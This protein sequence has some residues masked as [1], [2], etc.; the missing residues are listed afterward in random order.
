M[1]SDELIQIAACA[2]DPADMMLHDIADDPRHVA[3]AEVRRHLSTVGDDFKVA[4]ELEREVS[5]RRLRQLRNQLSE[6]RPDPYQHRDLRALEVDRHGL[7]ELRLLE[8]GQGGF[9]SG[10]TVFE[11][12]PSIDARNSSYWT[13]MSLNEFERELRPRIRL[14][15]LMRTRRDR[16]RS[17]MY[18]MLVYGRPLRW[19]CVLELREE[20]HHRWTP[21]RQGGDV[22]FTDA[23]WTPRDNEV[24][25]RC[26]ECPTVSA[27]RYRPSRYLHAII[28]R[29]IG[30]VVHTDGALRIFDHDE[31]LARVDTHVRRAGKMGSRIK[32]FQLDGRLDTERWTELLQA[33]FIWNDDI[34]EFVG[35]LVGGAV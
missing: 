35:S 15:P 13:A 31:A 2:S 34:R 10:E 19:R 1:F 6:A 20:C 28:D 32:L 8:Q 5:A 9:A 29:S 33:F 30:A 18:K 14:D 12:M 16:Y 21:S 17:M 23:V 26:E 27:A 22:A 3:Y 11:I 24:H 7:I 4:R 25:L